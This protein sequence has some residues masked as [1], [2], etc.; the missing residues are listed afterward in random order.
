MTSTRICRNMKKATFSSGGSGLTGL[1]TAVNFMIVLLL[2][3]FIV[4]FLLLVN[5]HASS[6]MYSRKL[7]KR[8]QILYAL[9]K[10]YKQNDQSMSTGSQKELGKYR[11]KWGIAVLL[12]VLDESEESI[13]SLLRSMVREVG[14][15][16]FMKKQLESGDLAYCTLLIKLIGE[17]H[18]H[19]FSEYISV[20]LHK[21]KKD[22]ELQYVGFLSLSLLGDADTLIPICLEEDFTQALSFRSLK[23]IFKHYE[24][25]REQLCEALLGAP[26]NYLRRVALNMV[27]EYSLQALAPR[28][29]KL[30]HVLDINIVIDAIRALGQL[31]YEGAVEELFSL[32]DHERWEVRSAVVRALASINLEKYALQIAKGLS[33]KEWWVR[34]NAAAALADYSR[35]R[36]LQQ[37]R[38][39]QSDRFAS[40]VLQYAIQRK[41]IRREVLPA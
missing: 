20:Y 19:G 11:S 1:H 10:E 32:M 15:E 33:D 40:E 38:Y 8:K 37:S 16:A 26:D 25:D 4:V 12:E 5:V 35:V 30:L 23:E 24:G 31:R 17:L 22:A 36:E 14:F 34:Y 13:D 21:Y 18:V 41:S 28:M 9:M 6:Y 3:A 39:V 27:G 7:K 29:M 2:V